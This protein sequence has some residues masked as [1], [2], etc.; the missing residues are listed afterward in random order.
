MVDGFRGHADYSDSDEDEPPLAPPEDD[1]ADD[2]PNFGARAAA[3]HGGGGG[4]DDEPRLAPLS[5]AEESTTGYMDH[6]FRIVEEVYA[7]S[8]SS[9]SEV[10]MDAVRAL[11]PH[12]GAVDSDSEVGRWVRWVRCSHDWVYGELSSDS[13]NLLVLRT[14]G[15]GTFVDLG[16]G[17]GKVA[18]LASLYFS[19]VLGLELQGALLNMASSLAEDFRAQTQK[20]GV[21]VGELML[22]C[23]DFLGRL[24][25]HWQSSQRQCWWE[26]ADVAYACS[27]KFCEAT[28]HALDECAARMKSGS[29]F[30][31]V[32]HPLHS[33]CLEEIWRGEANF[34]WGS[35]QLIVYRHQ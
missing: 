11:H 23:V 22:H 33:P 4:D 20:H 18:A 32:R 17:T 2:D 14:G 3:A 26:V 27:P 29:H 1:A 24:T 15:G 16:C 5:E 6:G 34:S 28:M 8:C 10:S 13:F 30:V 31:T 19:Q 21:A 12:W 7:R 25:P 35:D 9:G